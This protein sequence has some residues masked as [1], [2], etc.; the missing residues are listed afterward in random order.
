MADKLAVIV[1]VVAVGLAAYLGM[2]KWYDSHSTVEYAMADFTRGLSRADGEATYAALSDAY[3]RDLSRAEWDTSVL[4]TFKPRTS[5]RE[6]ELV[7]Q[8]AINDQ[9]NAYPADG[10]PQRFVYNFRLQ[11]RDYQATIIAYKQGSS[12]KIDEFQGEYK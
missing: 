7:R 10:D 12:W 1:V 9:F 8:E 4:Q 11:E 5:E 2:T 3:R 6:P